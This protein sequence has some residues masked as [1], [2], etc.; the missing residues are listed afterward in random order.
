MNCKQL[1]FSLIL[2]GAALPANAQLTVTN[3]VLTK[4][5]EPYQGIGIN[6][7]TALIQMISIEGRAVDPTGVMCREGMQTLKKYDIP[8]I[9]FCAGGFFPADW[10]LYLTDKETYFERFDLL[11]ELAEKYNIGL[12]PSL[13]W[14]YPTVPDL[15]GEHINQWG[16]PESKTHEFMRRYTTEVVSRYKDSPAIWMWEFGNEYLAA[17]DLPGEEHG[18][19]MVVTDYGTPEHRT[20]ED[21]MFRKNVWVAYQEFAKTVRT[22]DEVRPVGTGDV[23]PRFSAHHNWAE[24]SWV[25]DNPEQWKKIFLKDNEAM[26]TL[27]VHFYYD[28][29]ASKVETGLRFFSMEQMIKFLMR[30]SDYVKKP[31]F[32][33]EFGPNGYD[34]TTKVEREQFEFLLDL[35]KKQNVPLSALWNFEFEHGDQVP[36]N[37]TE[38]NH[39][40]YMLKA[41]QDANLELK[42]RNS[43]E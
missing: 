21:K 5:G 35:I 12:I 1:I 25:A 28:S 4:D 38:Q 32:I 9:R 13:F 11:V 29:D 6:Y 37:I 30:C 43:G 24:Q 18:R 31:L 39:R 20:P 2:S 26:D 40:A 8:F 42:R 15:V 41:L 16:N 23:M 27:A 7:F 10:K 36:W 22:M 34:K 17:A 19:G 3:G 14:Y 33:G